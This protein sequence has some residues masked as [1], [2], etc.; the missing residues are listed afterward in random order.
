MVYK[1]LLLVAVAFLL[2][3]VGFVSAFDANASIIGNKP[4]INLNENNSINLTIGAASENISQIWL[5][6][7][8]N[9]AGSP[10]PDLFINGTNITT[11]S[12]VEF[13]DTTNYS[14]PVTRTYNLTFFNTSA[15]SLVNNGSSENF[16][17]DIAAR[18]TD[19]GT[20]AL[21][22]LTVRMISSD[23]STNET[24]ISMGPSFAFTGYILNETGCST[25]FQNGTNASIYGVQFQVDGPPVR[26]LLASTMTNESGFFRISE[27]NASATF[28]GFQLKTIFYNGS[29][30]A[31]KVGMIMPEFPSF[32]YYG[33]MSEGGFDM[34]LNGAT[35]YLQQAATIN[36]SAT[37]GSDQV[38]F[39]YEI[40]DEVLG[41]P[42]ENSVQ[43]KITNVA[44]VVPAG[45][46]Y[47]TSIYRM[48]GKPGNAV[49]YVY[50]DTLCGGS[51]FMNDTLCPSPP[52]SVS[53]G[54]LNASQTF[55][56]NQSL[57]VR[58]ANVYGC[59]N[60][61]TGTNSTAVNIT[62]VSIKMLPWSSA[63]GSFVPPTSGDDGTLNI[64]NQGQL[65]TTY[66]GCL[67]WYNFSLL[68][69]TSYMIEFYAKNVSTE[70]E[71]SGGSNTLAGFQNITALNTMQQNITMY[72]LAGN[73]VSGVPGLPVNTSAVKINIVNSTGG[74]VTTS[75]SA[76]VKVKNNAAGIGTVYY[77]IQTFTNGTFY[78]PI[79][80][81]SNFAKVM[82]FSNNGPP[83]EVS[84]NLSAPETN[85]SLI[86]MDAM[87]KGFRK[88]NDTGGLESVNTSSIPIQ[89]RFLRNSAGCDV[90]NAPDSCVVTSM[91]A[92]DFNPLKALLAGKVNMEVKITSTNVSLIFRDYDMMTAKQ[93]PMNSI[94]EENASSRSSSGGVVEEIW[95]FGSFAP[96]D[97]YSNVSIVI[98]YSDTSTAANYI[99]DSLPVNLSTGLLYDENQNVI[100][101]SSTGDGPNNV[102]DDYIAY[103]GTYYRNILGSGG[104]LCSN[105]S[106]D[107][108]CYINVTGNYIKLE[109]PHFSSLGAVVSGSGATA[110]SSSE[111]ESSSGGGSGTITGSFWTRTFAFDGKDI[112][113]RDPIT[114]AMSAKQRSK[115]KVEGSV[116]HVGVVSLDNTT[117]TINVSSNPQSATLGV[118]ESAKFDVTE[119]NFYD[120]QV[121][122]LEIVNSKANVTIE[123]IN[124]AVPEDSGGDDSGSADDGAGDSGEGGED[125]A[126]EASGADEL[127]GE[128]GGSSGV[129]KALIWVVII[130]L[131]LGIVGF[132]AFWMIKG[133][134]FG[135]APVAPKVKKVR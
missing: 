111:E 43:S 34:S 104:V 115:I 62:S 92:N 84:V 48:P 98:P 14:A 85:I 80:N 65:N 18:R 95:D 83:K 127:A 1:K 77:I 25:C 38:S 128:G 91:N 8:A 54:T 112:D 3:G 70:D 12:G 58:R 74:A 20:G 73:Y 17:I 129:A 99:N 117:A 87:D 66:S 90:P 47:T 109:I 105:S 131:I 31:T 2:V 35:F 5:I 30:T 88:L 107:S 55:I 113:D 119:N 114:I 40:I 51:D 7:Q 24:T 133:N 10:L 75:V 120:I 28:Q 134:P 63:S 64:T 29:G 41:F 125:S 97:S 37:N 81:N 13:N 32:M 124:E 22:S 56:I 52:K 72:K 23:G 4:Y 123:A 89:L 69:E 42:I 122:L 135:G 68:N 67:A 106:F 59:I 27:V 61:A 82:V 33:G 50:N 130:L 96:S 86:S 49:G 126:E 132:V 71:D 102:S 15:A 19:A 16:T 26:T 6:Y 103:N 45:R 100:W 46:A 101:N 121:T 79:L 21:F 108:V 78:L 116:H 36:I 39:G 57:A 44:V 53:T 93:P 9:M 76:D 118:G 60:P 94:L 11:A 110:A